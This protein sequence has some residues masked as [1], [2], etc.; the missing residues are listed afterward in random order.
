MTSAELLVDAFGRVQE[1]VHE[2]VRGLTS[3]LFR[4][5]RVPGNHYTMFH[6]EN[7]GPVIQALDRYL[8]GAWP[9]SV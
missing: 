4:V 7:I 1:T 2:A 9:S 8:A 3:G 5:V 6:P